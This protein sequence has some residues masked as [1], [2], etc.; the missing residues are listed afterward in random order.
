V[1][2]EKDSE[3]PD[4]ANAMKMI[5]HPGRSLLIAPEPL[6]LENEPDETQ[7]EVYRSAFLDLVDFCNELPWKFDKEKWREDSN[8]E[9]EFTL[10]VEGTV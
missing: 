3:D 4:D 1:I 9:H 6:L 10:V 2:V 7:V 8:F 5:V